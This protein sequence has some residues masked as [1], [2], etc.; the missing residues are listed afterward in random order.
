M[1]LRGWHQA[2]PKMPLWLFGAGEAR[3]GGGSGSGGGRGSNQD[4]RAGQRVERTE[5]RVPVARSA[6]TTSANSAPC[7]HGCVEVALPQGR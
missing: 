3:A 5:R 6:A 2:L 4:T 1:V 7:W